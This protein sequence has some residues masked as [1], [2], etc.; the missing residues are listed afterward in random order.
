[1]YSIIKNYNYTANLKFLK[2]DI[3][4]AELTHL[5]VSSSKELKDC[6]NILSVGVQNDI[7]Q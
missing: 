2:S 6:S 4:Y 5:C 7:N 1:M 3:C